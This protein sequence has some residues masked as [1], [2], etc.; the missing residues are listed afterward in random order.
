MTPADE[1]A[2]RTNAGIVIVGSVERLAHVADEMQQEF[3]RWR[4]L[5]V[6]PLEWEHLCVV[7][8]GWERSAPPVP[9]RRNSVL[10][11]QAVERRPADP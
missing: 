9:A 10:P 5:S 3:R 2:L 4:P 8:I 6:R 1:I 7:R 11:Q